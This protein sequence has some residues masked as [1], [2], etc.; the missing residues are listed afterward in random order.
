[1][2]TLIAS[3][4]I[5]ATIS[6]GVS[7]IITAFEAVLVCCL[8]KGYVDREIKYMGEEMI[9]LANEAIKKATD[10]NNEPAAENN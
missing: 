1:M 10:S 2:N 7:I 6:T 5:S 3:A 4:I 8:Y 9:K